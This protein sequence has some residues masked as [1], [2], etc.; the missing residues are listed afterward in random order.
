MPNSLESVCIFYTFFCL[1]QKSVGPMLPDCPTG[2]RRRRAVLLAEKHARKAAARKAAATQAPA[3]NSWDPE[4]CPWD[5]HAPFSLENQQCEGL[6][7]AQSRCLFK[8]P[9]GHP[10]ASKC[11]HESRFSFLRELLFQSPVCTQSFFFG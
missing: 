6:P 11:V 1:S 7:F 10:L 9:F 2:S 5:H 4:G 8:Y 3:G